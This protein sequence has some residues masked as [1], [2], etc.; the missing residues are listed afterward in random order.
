MPR[1]WVQTQHL[2]YQLFCPLVLQRL[3]KAYV[4]LKDLLVDLECTVCLGSKWQVTIDELVKH[5]SN[6]P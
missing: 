4:S 1:L 6:G 3:R 5:D 2:F